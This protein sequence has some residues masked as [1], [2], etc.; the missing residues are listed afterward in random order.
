MSHFSTIATT[1]LHVSFLHLIAGLKD[2]TGS[3]FLTGF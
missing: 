3:I 1:Q 2:L